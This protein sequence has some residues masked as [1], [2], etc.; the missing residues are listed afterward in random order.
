MKMATLP[1]QI[2]EDEDHLRERYF[3]EPCSLDDLADE[4][5]CSQTVIIEAFEIASTRSRGGGPLVTQVDELV[6]EHATE[7]RQLYEREYVE[8]PELADHFDVRHHAVLDAMNELGIENRTVAER[9]ADTAPL[10][11]WYWDDHL[12]TYGIA[13]RL[14]VG[15]NCVIK[16]MEEVG[17][18]RRRKGF[19]VQEPTLEPPFPEQE[20]AYLAGI[21]DGEGSIAVRASPTSWDGKTPELWVKMGA[22]DT[23][24]YLQNVWDGSVNT[25]E[26]KDDPSR[27]TMWK[28]NAGKIANT[29][30]ILDA[31]EDHLIFR[32]DGA[33]EV[34][35]YIE[36]HY[37]RAL[38]GVAGD[39]V[40]RRHS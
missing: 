22:P 34:L 23:I 40:E 24:Q 38:P 36:R 21:L 27:Q 32:A 15:K 13:D 19:Q 26:R 2:A 4:Y 30:L 9:V 7:V 6:D 14:G 20:V 28:W 12:S 1:E 8:P 35:E 39:V 18:D 16:A 25:E 17:I 3:G 5:D 29:Y 11:E 37:G 31:V 33:A 10:E